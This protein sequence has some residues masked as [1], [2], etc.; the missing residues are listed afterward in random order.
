M[1]IG[2]FVHFSYVKSEKKTFSPRR[3]V[4]N[5]KGELVKNYE[6]HTYTGFGFLTK[7]TDCYY[8]FEMA[9]PSGRRWEYRNGKFVKLQI[10]KYNFSIIKN[11]GGIYNE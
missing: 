8:F 5:S 2:D 10:V 9:S 4:E 7:V 6:Y 1:K 11:Y 3:Y